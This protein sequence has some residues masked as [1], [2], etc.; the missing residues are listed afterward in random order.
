MTRSFLLPILCLF[1]ISATCNRNA[2]IEDNCIDAAKIDQEAAC[3]EI[4]KPVCGC[5]G[6]TYSNSCHAE[7]YGGVTHWEEGACED[8]Q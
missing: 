8:R 7:N 3:I 6:K 4:Y 1:L 5:D 2:A